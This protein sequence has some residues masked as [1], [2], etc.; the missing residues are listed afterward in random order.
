M[1]LAF[2]ALSIATL[3]FFYA[4]AHQALEENLEYISMLGVAINNY[5][6]RLM[7]ISGEGRCRVSSRPP[8]T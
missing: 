1:A 3:V 8:T 5:W 7:H 2:G 6:A 4:A